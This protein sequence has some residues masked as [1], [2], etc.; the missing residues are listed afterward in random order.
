MSTKEKRKLR[1]SVPLRR[2]ID[3]SANIPPVEEKTTVE[4]VKKKKGKGR[5]KRKRNSE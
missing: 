3:T 1:R 2:K 4:E 5:G